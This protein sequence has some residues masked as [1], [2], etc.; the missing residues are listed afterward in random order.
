[1][2]KVVIFAVAALLASTVAQAQTYVQGYTRADG[3]YVQ[4]HYR[5]DANSTKLDNYSTRGNVNP[6]TGERGTIDPYRDQGSPTY[7]QPP[8]RA[9]SYDRNDSDCGS[10]CSSYGG[11]Y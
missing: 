1:M 8:K 3:T 4:G 2:K 10:R 7:D 6:Y 5:S 9:S 11:G